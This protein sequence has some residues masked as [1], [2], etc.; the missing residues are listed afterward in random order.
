MNIA[1]IGSGSWGTAMVSQLAERHENIT[2]YTR[3]KKVADDIA[4]TRENRIYLPS[5]KIPM[6]VDVTTDLERAVTKADVVILST[7]AIAIKN[8]AESLRSLLAKDALVILTA[9]GLSDDGRRL[10]VVVEEALNGITNRIAVLSGPNHAEEVGKRQPAATVIAARDKQVAMKAQ[11]IYMLPRFRA[12]YST[13]LVGV[14]FGGVLK[15]IIA[16]AAGVVDGLAY[17]DNTRSALITR[18]L[19]EMVRYACHFGATQETLYGL[20]G[21]GDLVA[22][23]TSKHS[24]NAAAGRELAEGKTVQ[25][26]IGGTHMV[27][28]GIRTTEI[29]YPIAKQNRIDMPITEQVFNVLSGK[30]K[31]EETLGILLARE[32]KEEL[33]EPLI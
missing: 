18:G 11:D 26:I 14:E 21:I 25:E 19:T 33:Q 4:E 28:E 22:T 24:R 16:L 29:V 20:S 13:D 17:G 3:N 2:L 8:T 10:S 31:P 7:P 30:V 27:V 5:V 12:Y 1:M 23:C 9:K 15:N 6:H 32:K